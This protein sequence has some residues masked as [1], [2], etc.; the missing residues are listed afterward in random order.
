M[1]ALW[2]ALSPP[3]PL[4]PPGDNDNMRETRGEI[5]AAV[6]VL[7]VTFIVLGRIKCVD[8]PQNVSSEVSE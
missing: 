7:C 6:L 2:E 3:V 1:E 4:S 5:K 8:N